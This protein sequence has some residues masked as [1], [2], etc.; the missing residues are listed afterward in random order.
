VAAEPARFTAADRLQEVP[1]A[2]SAALVTRLT[3]DADALAAFLARLGE[4]GTA[5]DLTD[6]LRLTLA[7]GRVVHLRPSG[8]APELRFYA[9]AETPAAAAALLAAGLD[10]LRETLPGDAV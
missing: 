1:T 7:S 5:R 4:T 8:N 6:G 10:R 2:H 3:E 9:E